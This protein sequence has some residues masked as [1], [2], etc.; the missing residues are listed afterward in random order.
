MSFDRR[1]ALLKRLF[2]TLAESE[3]V[4]AIDEID[5]NILEMLGRV[6]VD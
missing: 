1:L 3:L 6:H 5:G 2:P 4:A